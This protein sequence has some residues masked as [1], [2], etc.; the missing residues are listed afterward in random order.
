[1]V[2][3][4]GAV[5]RLCEGVESAVGSRGGYPAG[6]L[7]AG[8]VGE[9]E[10]RLLGPLRAAEQVAERPVAAELAQPRALGPRLDALGDDADAVRMREL[11]DGGDDRVVLEV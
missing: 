8:A 10:L 2:D 9:H 1:M 4:D 3:C 11:D 7:P 6:A 5:L